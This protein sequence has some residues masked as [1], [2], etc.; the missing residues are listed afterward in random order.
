MN[1]QDITK[2]SSLSGKRLFFTAQQINCSDCPVPKHYSEHYVKKHSV[3]ICY[4]CYRT[5]SYNCYI[6]L[7]IK[8]QLKN[9]FMWKLKGLNFHLAF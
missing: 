1:E 3:K 2:K 7:T 4:I 5:L 9:I 6:L 8:T